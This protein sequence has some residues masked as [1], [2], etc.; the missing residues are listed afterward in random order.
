MK[1]AL[2]QTIQVLGLA[3]T[4][5]TAS[6]GEVWIRPDGTDNTGDGS[7][8]NPYVRSSASSFDSLMNG[9]TIGPNTKIHLMAGTFLTLQGVTLKPG[10]KIIGAGMDVT[11]I[12]LAPVSSPILDPLI[13]GNMEPFWYYAKDNVEV[14]D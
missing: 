8:A 5:L 2:T 14:S 3:L 12:Q 1:T 9:A 11:V 4:V 10:W 13:G 7:V 6:A